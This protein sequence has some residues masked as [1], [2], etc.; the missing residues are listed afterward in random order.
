MR[1]RVP[2][3]WKRLRA[4]YNKT[5]V[6]NDAP[7]TIPETKPS[8]AYI[9]PSIQGWVIYNHSFFSFFVAVIDQ[10]S[11]V[12][13]RDAY[14]VE[15]FSLLPRVPRFPSPFRL[16][17]PDSALTHQRISFKVTSKR[18]TPCNDLSQWTTRVWAVFLP[19]LSL[20]VCVYVYVCV[21]LFVSVCSI[22]YA[23]VGIHHNW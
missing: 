4:K 23:C 18:R 14:R 20:Y 13:H 5:A 7:R 21:C 12:Y 3:S 11:S 15:F 17:L 6:L 19:S 22:T 10:H 1:I 8:I 2:G 16:L 9:P